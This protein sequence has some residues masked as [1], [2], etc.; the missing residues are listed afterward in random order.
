MRSYLKLTKPT[1]TTTAPE[2]FLDIF[3]LFFFNLKKLKLSTLNHDLPRFHYPQPLATTIQLCFYKVD[4]FRFHIWVISYINQFSSVQLLS[5]VQLFAT[6]W[7]AARHH[8]LLEFTQTHVHHQLPVFT[9][10]HV[11]WVG[12]AIRPS[13]PL[14]S[15][16]PPAIVFI[17]LRNCYSSSTPEKVILHCT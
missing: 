15:P 5:C 4:S 11:H 14:S 3:L 13:Y 16:S 7:T 1:L 10:T 6:P 17:S 9:Q 2:K 8:Q 12:D